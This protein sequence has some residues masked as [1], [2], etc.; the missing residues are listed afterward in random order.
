MPLI[1]IRL[2][3]MTQSLSNLMIATNISTPLMLYVLVISS[4]W[5][6]SHLLPL[7]IWSI[8]SQL[9]RSMPR[10]KFILNTAT[11]KQIRLLLV[12]H[13]L[14]I[15]FS[16]STHHTLR[17]MNGC[18]NAS[19]AVHL[20]SG[21]RFKQ[22]SKRSRKRLSSLLSESLMPFVFAPSLVRR[23]RVGLAKGRMR[24]TS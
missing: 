10:L 24:T 8:I 5:V 11:M 9:C 14:F 22:R 7:A 13:S 6:L 16:F 20:F 17:M 18:F 21:L 12:S 15:L 23:S 19:L 2:C 3:L 4:S 1:S